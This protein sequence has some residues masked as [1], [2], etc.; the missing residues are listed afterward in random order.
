MK[1]ITK[2]TARKL[3]NEKKSFWMT[4][5]NMRPEFGVLVGS[6]SFSY[7]ASGDWTFDQLV[8]S[9]TYYNCDNER[10]R[11]PTYYVED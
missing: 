5:C 4:A 8:N 7:E 1:K 3:Y 6:L 2:S 9:F 10:G 11:Y